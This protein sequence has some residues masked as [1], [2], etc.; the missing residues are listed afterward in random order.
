MIVG[1]TGTLKKTLEFPLSFHMNPIF[2]LFAVLQQSFL[3]R[4]TLLISHPVER[5]KNVSRVVGNE[6][7]D[8]QNVQNAIN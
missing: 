1:N 8:T 4:G 2:L 6:W 5:H 3:K 7:M